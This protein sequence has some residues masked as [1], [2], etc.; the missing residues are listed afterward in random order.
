[1]VKK[2]MLLV[3]MTISSLSLFSQNVTQNQEFIKIPVPVVRKIVVDL[4]RGDSAIAQLHQSNLMIKQLENKTK[5]QDSIIVSYK[6]V[7]ENN[8]K[9]ISNLERKVEI[10]ETEFKS[11]SKELRKQK[12]KSRFTNLLSSGTIVT[13]LYFV[14]TK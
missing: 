12:I 11:V 8:Q 10:V 9:I 14:I 6:Q 3:A 13:L 2:L 1:M 5:V 4:V 7:D